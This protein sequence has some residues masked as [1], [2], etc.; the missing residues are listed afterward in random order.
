[1]GTIFMDMGTI[2]YEVQHLSEGR[3]IS[4]SMKYSVQKDRNVKLLI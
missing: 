3:A 2:S 1:M 4:F